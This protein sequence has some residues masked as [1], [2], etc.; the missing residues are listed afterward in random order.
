MVTM[1][2]HSIG[3]KHFHKDMYKAMKIQCM[4]PLEQVVLSTY[5]GR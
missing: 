1:Y 3:D 4:Q 5:A 2:H